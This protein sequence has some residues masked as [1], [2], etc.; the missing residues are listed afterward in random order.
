MP[1]SKCSVVL[2]YGIY[3]KPMPLGMTEDPK[4]KVIVKRQ[5][6]KEARQK[7]EAVE[8]IDDVLQASFQSSLERLQRTLDLL[9]PPEL[10]GLYLHKD[11]DGDDNGE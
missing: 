2:I 3:P 7:L 5:L 8:G 9:I 11:E 10:E 1:N 6:I 4:T